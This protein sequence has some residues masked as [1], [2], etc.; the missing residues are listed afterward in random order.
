MN[1]DDAGF[2]QA[3]RQAW[4]DGG[5]LGLLTSALTAALAE[6]SSSGRFRPMY[7]IYSQVTYLLPPDLMRGLRLA[8]VIVVFVSLLKLIPRSTATRKNQLAY[9]WVA[10][11]FFSNYTLFFGLQFASFQE[12]TGITFI[13]IGI[14]NKNQLWRFTFFA[15]AASTKELFIPLLILYGIYLLYRQF[16]TLGIVSL[17]LG[18]VLFIPIVTL[19]PNGYYTQGAF[20]INPWHFWSNVQS[21]ASTGALTV[22][23]A[24]IGLVTLR[25]RLRFEL[26]PVV[27]LLA[28]TAYAAGL[29]FWWAG[30]YY[31]SPVWYLLTVGLAMASL[32]PTQ[33]ERLHT[34]SAGNRVT[35]VAS[36]VTVSLCLIASIALF[37][38]TLRA[39]VIGWNQT[40]VEARDWVLA[41]APRGTTYFL[42]DLNPTEFDFY[43]REE[44]PT[45]N[46]G[47]SSYW[48]ANRPRPAETLGKD[49]VIASTV[50][51]VPE[52]LTNCPPIKVWTRGFLAP[53]KC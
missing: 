50:V 52:E 48:Q 8:S 49:F 51:G 26:E 11:L 15:F 35:A 14:L 39:D 44:D 13:A 12:L 37:L 30:G 53:L 5:L 41:E 29:L 38:E 46:M 34:E 22:F 10:A 42:F 23:V 25:Q 7:V 40:Y 36:V 31:T 24:L 1:G 9:V 32:P 3:S 33:H 2:V 27:F 18:F 28:S 45:W 20:D 21:L 16:R 19:S 43:L 4:K 6:P 17:I 47:P